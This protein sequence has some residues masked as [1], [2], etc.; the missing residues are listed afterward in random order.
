VVDASYEALDAMARSPRPVPA[1]PVGEGVDEP[2]TSS[3]PPDLAAPRA[4][5]VAGRDVWLIH[6]WAL[7]EPP[8]DLPAGCLRVGWWP[9]EHHAAWP[10]SEARWAFVGERLS[11]L[12]PLRW[13]GSRMQLAQALAAARSV[14][15]LSDPHVGALLPPL[16]Q[17]RAPLSLFARVDRP[18]ASFSTWWNRGT[19]GVRRLSQLP[20]LAALLA[21]GAAGPLFERASG[22]PTDSTNRES[23]R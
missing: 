9:T 1:R 18:C 7:G 12:A 14:Q 2:L 10:W 13:H 19:R 8:A 16:V 5:D 17:Q 22:A 4:G 20:G 15:T 21:S 6:P 3:H 11:A 23:L